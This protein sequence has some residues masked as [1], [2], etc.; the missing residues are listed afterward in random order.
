MIA[1]AVCELTAL[2]PHR[3]NDPFGTNSVILGEG[4]ETPEWTR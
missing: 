2:N 3:A 4:Y 1:A